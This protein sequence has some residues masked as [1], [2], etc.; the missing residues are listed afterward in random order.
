MQVIPLF[1]TGQFVML[2][3][4]LAIIG[5]IIYRMVKMR[6][7]RLRNETRDQ[8]NREKGVMNDEKIKQLERLNELKKSGALTEE[9]FEDQKRKILE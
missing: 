3:L 1:P 6:D 7:D 9:E 5:A 4:A 2:A 8:M